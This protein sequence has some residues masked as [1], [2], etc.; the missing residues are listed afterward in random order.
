MHGVGTSA[1]H[2]LLVVAAA[3]AVNTAVMLA[4]K[5]LYA[6]FT[7]AQFGIHDRDIEGAVFTQGLLIGA[8]V[9]TFVAVRWLT[10]V[11]IRQVFILLIGV[12]PICTFGFLVIT[13][14]F[15]V[16]PPGHRW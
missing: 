4:L 14:A 2:R 6:A 3:V 8:L 10:G 12:V 5:F 11:R 16:M 9:F 7:R 15:Q 13:Y 1:K